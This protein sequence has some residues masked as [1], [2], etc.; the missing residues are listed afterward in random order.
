[1]LSGHEER[2][3]AADRETREFRIILEKSSFGEKEPSACEVHRAAVFCCG[4]ARE[5]YKGLYFYKKPL[6]QWMDACPPK[7]LKEMEIF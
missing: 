2:L 3:E 1:M 7:S 6:F 4:V 5:E